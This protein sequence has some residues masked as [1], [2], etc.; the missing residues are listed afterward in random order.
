MKKNPKYQD[1]VKQAAFE[2]ACDDIFFGCNRG[3][4]KQ[5][6]HNLGL[7]EEESNAV[8]HEAWEYMSNQQ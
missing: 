7:T 8:W 3:Y 6:E 2:N 5:Y 4:W 1:S